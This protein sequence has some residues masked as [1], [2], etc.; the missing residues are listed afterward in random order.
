MGSDTVHKEN[1]P[2]SET[3]TESGEKMNSYMINKIFKFKIL[4][5]GIGIHK[6]MNTLIYIIYY[7]I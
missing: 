1:D 3:E 2:S 6:L 4:G 7:L 5:I